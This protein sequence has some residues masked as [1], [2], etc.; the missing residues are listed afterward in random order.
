MYTLDRRP[1]LS[2][3]GEGRPLCRAHSF[4]RDARGSVREEGDTRLA[5]Q[6]SRIN[7]GDQ[8]G[9]GCH[10]QIALTSSV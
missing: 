6:V 5:G 2:A 8:W 7:P 3:S 4:G 9:D 10:S 1:V